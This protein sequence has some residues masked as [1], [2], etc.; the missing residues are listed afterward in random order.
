MDSRPIQSN[1]LSKT[2]GGNCA[3]KKLHQCG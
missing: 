3:S 1:T 2:E